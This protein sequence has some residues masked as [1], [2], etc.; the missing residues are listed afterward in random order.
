MLVLLSDVGPKDGPTRIRVGS[1]LD[2]AR[3]LAPHG[4]RGLGA[5][6]PELLGLYPRDERP[7]ALATGRAGDVLLCHPFLVHSAQA[8]AGDHVRFMTQPPLPPV[9]LLVLDRSDGD[10][11]P[12]ERAVRRAL[13]DPA[14]P[15]DLTR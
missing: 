14:P 5:T 1:H 4:D 9:G 8:V 2:I 7:V 12:V 3:V 6:D 11:S 13:G 15:S 10:H